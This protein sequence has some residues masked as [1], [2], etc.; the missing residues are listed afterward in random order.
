MQGL[1][2]D[3]QGQHAR[4]RSH[5]PFMVAAWRQG[6]GGGSEGLL[7]VDVLSIVNLGQ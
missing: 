5:G 2:R 1:L 3:M 4:V 6:G 7:S